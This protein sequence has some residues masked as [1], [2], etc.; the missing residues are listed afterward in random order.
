[1]PIENPEVLNEADPFFDETEWEE[2]ESEKVY[3]TYPYKS[4]RPTPR[5][6]AKPEDRYDAELISSYA[7]GNNE[8]LHRL[9]QRYK[10][11]IYNYLIMELNE[12][13][14]SESAVKVYRAIWENIKSK[15]QSFNNEQHVV[16]FRQY[17]FDIVDDEL[18]KCI[19]TT[20]LSCRGNNEKGE[21]KSSKDF[22]KAQ[23]RAIFLF[24]TRIHARA[25]VRV[26]SIRFSGLTEDSIE[27]LVSRA[28]NRVLSKK[29][30]LQLTPDFKLWPYFKAIV[31]NLIKD[32]WRKNK[33]IGSLSSKPQKTLAMSSNPLK[34]VELYGDV[35]V[36]SVAFSRE[37]NHLAWGT[38]EKRIRLW[39]IGE[40][41]AFEDLSGHEKTVNG[42][43]FHSQNQTLISGSDD[44][45]VR[46]W[47][48]NSRDKSNQLLTMHPQGV[49]CIS[50]SP[51]GH[52]LASASRDGTICLTDT[53]TQKL[54][55][56]YP[57][58]SLVSSLAFSPD[59]ALLAC[60]RFDGAVHLYQVAGITGD[61]PIPLGNHEKNVSSLAFSPDGNRLAVGVEDACVYL[62]DLATNTQSQVLKKHTAPV[63]AI[64]FKPD[65]HILA[66]ASADKT[67][68][69][70][71]PETGQQVASIQKLRG[72]TSLAYS[73]DGSILACGLEKDH[74]LISG[75]RMIRVDSEE[76]QDIQLPGPSNME[77]A[78][79]YELIENKKILY[80]FSFKA[81]HQLTENEKDVINLKPDLSWNEVGH[82]LGVS[83]ETARTR[84]QSGIRK[85][86]EFVVKDILNEKDSPVLN[87]FRHLS[88]EQKEVIILKIKENMSWDKIVEKLKI[89]QDIT[90]S[91]DQIFENLEIPLDEKEKLIRK[92]KLNM[93]KQYYI[94]GINIM[95]EY[96]R[97]S[98][99]YNQLINERS[100]TIKTYSER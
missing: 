3:K 28:W 75:Y 92:E 42:V 100:S 4:Y 41:M 99:P 97:M 18:D 32:D 54:I 47:E 29:V 2:A 89:P 8:S 82:A 93:A 72:I 34:A 52:Y 24:V 91:W 83:W 48:I 60:G 49:K 50:L 55:K 36:T 94:S 51:D 33:P 98:I 53:S 22:S 77:P 80:E 37:G 9:H 57:N 73:S 30:P 58:E 63:T 17:L 96:V 84:Y 69:L 59:G 44:K 16:N 79:E 65:G 5:P 12:P 74:R 62:W 95:G 31:H 20:V 43:I 87:A 23:N 67:I 6:P 70:W 39:K 90:E 56:S 38:F 61:T 88:K 68:R 10:E 27:D 66:S 64:A 35:H 76:G 7:Q 13:V 26:A 14:N 40:I 85:M 86:G 19:I 21:T 81:L 46:L 1:M 15:Q 71:D 45:T 25:Y 11:D 78:V